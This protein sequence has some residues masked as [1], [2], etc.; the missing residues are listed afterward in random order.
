MT[1]FSKTKEKKKFGTL[2]P[3]L[4]RMRHSEDSSRSYSLNGWGSY[5]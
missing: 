3:Q 5:S 4:I 1:S 2:L